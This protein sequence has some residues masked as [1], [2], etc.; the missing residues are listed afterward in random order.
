[1]S[2]LNPRVTIIIPVYDYSNNLE[3]AVDSAIAQTYKNIEII[4]VNNIQNNSKA[5][6]II[7]QYGSRVRCYE[8]WVNSLPAALNY[9]IDKASGSYFCWLTAGCR[10]DTNAISNLVRMVDDTE[11]KIIV[12][13]WAFVDKEY[14]NPE[15]RGINKKIELNFKAFLGLSNEIEKLNTTSMLFPVKEFKKHAKFNESVSAFNDIELL[16]KLAHAGNRYILT[17]KPVLYCPSSITPRIQLRKP[18]AIEKIDFTRSEI[19]EKLEYKDILNYF[20]GLEG[21]LAYYKELLP[22]KFYRSKAMLIKK[23]VEG[24]VQAGDAAVKSSITS[25]LSMLPVEKLGVDIDILINKIK[26]PSKRK[27]IMFSTAHWLTG[28]IERVISTLFTELSNKYEIFLITPY[29]ARDS[30]IEIPSHVTSIKISNEAFAYNFDSIILAY[31]LLLDIDI[32]IGNTN[33]FERQLN[34]YNICVGTKIKTIASNHEYYFYPYKSEH[35]YNVV[36]KRLSAFKHANAIIWPNNF[37]AALCGEYIN[38]SYVIGNPN[39]FI[40]PSNNNATENII[41]CV[42][43]FND[44]VK[45]IDRIFESFSIILKKVPDARLVLVGKYDFD[46][47]IENA[48]NITIRGLI[49]RFKIPQ[50][51]YE[52]TGEV[53]NVQDCYS[54]AKVLMLTSNS[55]GFGMVLTEAASFGVPAVVN[56]IPGIEDIIIEGKNGY[57]TEQGDVEGMA[58]RV[59]EILSSNTIWKNLSQ[60]ALKHVRSFDSKNIGKKWTYLIDTLL[61]ADREDEFYAKLQ[62]RIGYNILDKHKYNKVLANELNDIFYLLVDNSSIQKAKIDELKTLVSNSEIGQTKGGG[63]IYAKALGLPKRIKANIGYEG[64]SRTG[65]KIATRS[66]RIVRR[67]INK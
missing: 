29:D 22:S 54:Q 55:E 28:G 4:V 16:Y 6:N 41:L 15:W 14:E 48:Q 62:Q 20:N 67:K 21:A 11:N 1:M 57:I 25:F 63:A 37:S 33:M 26:N 10:Y 5:K 24:Q 9:G 12:S 23:I 18:M 51:S 52:F 43:R 3:E 61:Q 40:I 35:F 36:E 32:V 59:C 53:D 31:S 46:A 13:G 34:L 49:D 27:K 65:K 19:I 60:G 7:K 56:F 17:N 45:R 50:D 64:L 8:H 30:K 66:Y 2:N 47:P 38:N 44:Y 42:G 39:K 58:L